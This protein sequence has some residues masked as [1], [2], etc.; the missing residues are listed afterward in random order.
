MAISF[1]NVGIKK[2]NILFDQALNPQPIGIKTPLE[3]NANGFGPF[4]MIYDPV[5]QLKDNLRNLIS[6]NSGERLGRYNYG[7]NLRSLSFDLTAKD[8]FD[9]E[10]AFRIKNAVRNYMPM[11]ELDELETTPLKIT[12]IDDANKSIAKILIKVKF[13]VPKAR[14]FD[15][16]VEVIIYA[17]G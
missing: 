3:V 2:D 1:K 6:T 17:G 4:Q 15:E 10:V 14:S 8:D 9:A 7:A 13:N 11:I 16:V 5:K 12:K